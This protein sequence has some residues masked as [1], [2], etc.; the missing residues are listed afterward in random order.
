MKKRWH[1][2]SSTFL[3]PKAWDLYRAYFRERLGLYFISGCT[4]TAAI[5][6]FGTGESCHAR[7]TP[8]VHSACHC[9][10]LQTCS[11]GMEGSESSRTWGTG[12][13][14]ELLSRG[15]VGR[16]GHKHLRRE[17]SVK[18][19]WDGQQIKAWTGSGKRRR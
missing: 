16:K 19:G 9:L 12:A 3:S 7:Q 18:R 11:R 17:K 1:Q 5:L 6:I 14:Q 13:G 8:A 10:Q 2:I 15:R 4:S